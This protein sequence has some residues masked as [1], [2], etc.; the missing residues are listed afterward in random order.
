MSITSNVS[1]AI[2]ASHLFPKEGWAQQQQWLAAALVKPC[3]QHAFTSIL[4]CV[5]LAIFTVTFFLQE[6]RNC[7]PPPAKPADNHHHNRKEARSILHPILLDCCAYLFLI[8]LAASVWETATGILIGWSSILVHSEVFAVLQTIGWFVIFLVSR[9]CNAQQQNRLK[10]LGLLQAWWILGFF[11]STLSILSGIFFSSKCK[12]HQFWDQPMWVAEIASF[13]AIMFLGTQALCSKMEI[14][15][16]DCIFQEPLL[17]ADNRQGDLSEREPITPYVTAGIFSLAT[18]SWLSP[19]LSVG[20]KKHLELKDLPHLAPKS[21]AHIAYEE[22][23]SSWEWLKQQNPSQAPSLVVAL[24]LSLWVEGTWNALFALINVCA[25]YVGPF[26][27]DDF[28]NY[29]GGRRRF[30]HEGLILVSIFFIAKIIENLANRQWYL[31]SQ[32]LGLR[33]KAALMAFLFHKGLRLSNQSRRSHTSAEIIN[34]MVVDVQKISDFTWSINHFWTLP[35]RIGLALAILSHVVGVAWVAALG[36]ALLIMFINTPLTKLL[37]KLQAKVMAAK[38]E[39]MKATSESLRNMRVLKLHAWDETYLAKIEDLRG[40]EFGWM[41]RHAL[42]MASTVYTFWTAPILVSTATFV[43]CVGLGIPLSAGKILTA[44]ATCRI[45]Q[46]PLDVF[47]E[48]IA[49]LAQTRVSSRITTSRITPQSL[50][51]SKCFITM[52][53]CPF[54]LVNHLSA[55]PMTQDF[56][57]SLFQVSVQ[58]LWRFLQE[59]ELPMDA[60]I[61]IP[62]CVDGGATKLDIVIEVREG[63]FSWDSLATDLTLTGVNLQVKRGVRVA[64]CGTVGSGKSSLLSCILGE[65]PKISGTVRFSSWMQFSLLIQSNIYCQS[66]GGGE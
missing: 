11:A 19:L 27:I 52:L 45:L 18:L 21:R 9:S 1:L 24:V 46:D 44:L 25:T 29:L 53:G 4:N 63:N 40:K 58:R 6:C 8:N 22:F 23:Q 5:F 39:R 66:W 65:I 51:L 33:M 20:A 14:E 48:F 37:E 16:E 50:T 54:L 15:L 42:V 43:T 26:L 31:G 61:H 60:V 30:A 2:A 13:P 17:S 41:W 36:A 35:V 59:P 62:S 57:T 32:I 3:F 28:V 34:Y 56:I 7:S 55:S 49:N 47:P 10:Y 12:D 38:D 64:V